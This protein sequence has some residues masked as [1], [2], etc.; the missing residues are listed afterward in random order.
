MNTIPFEK[1]FA[2]HEKSKYWSLKNELKPTEISKGSD[3]K[4]YFNCDKCNHEF[5]MQLNVV[6]RGGWCSICSGHKIC[7]NDDCK[8]CFNKSFASHEKSVFWSDK[9]ELTS[10]QVFKVSA[11]KYYFDC[12]KCGHEFINN[13]SHVSNG[14]WCP[15]CCIPQKNLCGA[16]DCKDCFEKSCASHEKSEFWS[17]KNEL[18]P[19]FVLKKGNKRIWFNCNKCNHDFET[20][21]KN[22]TKGQWCPYCNSNN[23]CVNEICGFCFEKS[24][25]SHEKSKCWS[26]KNTIS[27][28]QIVKGT[29]EKYWFNCD[30]CCHEFI[31]DIGSITCSRNGW[32]IYCANKK[33]CDNDDCKDCFNKS[34]ASHEKAKFWSLKNTKNPR[35]LFQG[36]SGRYWFNCD[37]CSHDFETVLYNV[38]SGYWCP[39]CSHSKLCDNDDCKDCFNKS[40]AS[41]EKVKC[42][43]IKNKET[44]RQ[45]FK[46]N[47]NKFWFNCDNCCH[48]FE[49]L[50]NSWCPYCSHSKLCDNDGCKD[51]FNKSFASHE[52]VKC[53]SIK[54]KETPR[55]LFQGT[56]QKYWFN[57]D[58][59]DHDFEKSLLHI[60][61]RNGWCPY[62]VNRKMCYED[63]CKDC[64]NK[65]FASHE[66][67]KC[68][69][70]KNK[71]TP[72]YLFQ[73]TAQKYWFNC[74]KCNLDFE[75]VLNYVKS[76]YWCPYCVNKTETKLYKI[77]K[78]KYPTIIHQFKVE[79]CKNIA[80]LPFDF[81]IPE[82]KI[83]IELDG[84]QHFTQIM[85][86]KTPEEQ[87]KRDKYKERCA[88]ENNYS[89]IRVIQNDVFND[90]YNWLTE[91]C[92]IIKE[93]KN[94]NDVANVYLCNNNEYNLY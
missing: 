87:F 3:K 6:T 14:R 2:S 47:N 66:K 52:K 89:V 1:S 61:G 12:D 20:Q 58:K 51:C 27:P 41:H 81:C 84:P 54:N 62:C 60:S 28:R 68:W 69:S 86:W 21:I 38:K 24:F 36:D 63:S 9:N 15:Y 49:T 56:A 40:F 31:K 48:D 11:K 45:T 35:H 78:E 18:K 73:G 17:S 34:F 57:C 80:Q 26:S 91:L 76:G 64:F 5:L 88:N 85:K 75:T 30:K 39:Y 79:W 37:K 77:L 53:W 55:Y 32:C 93:L 29:G 65:S 16:K 50:L 67:V 13:P 72:R 70:I 46:F 42:W 44:P 90:T 82:Y 33:M 4:C 71:E 83:I 94:G 8:E 23:L 25:A 43:S 19:E 22:I 59:C 74:D 10:R 7:L 92:E